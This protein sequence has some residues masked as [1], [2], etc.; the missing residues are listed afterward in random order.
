MQKNCKPMHFYESHAPNGPS[1]G[2]WIQECQHMFRTFPRNVNIFSVLD[3]FPNAFESKVG[4]NKF[5][6][7]V[8]FILTKYGPVASHGDLV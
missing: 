5:L 8:R 2:S 4:W 7:A 6:E 1:K 3:A